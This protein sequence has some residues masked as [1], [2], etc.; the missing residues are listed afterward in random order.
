MIKGLYRTLTSF[1]LTRSTLYFLYIFL[2][3]KRKQPTDFMELHFG[4]FE[5]LF[6]R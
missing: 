4:M 2:F 1:Y 6:D 3:Q 5:G